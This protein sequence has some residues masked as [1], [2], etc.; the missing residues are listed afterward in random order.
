[1]YL[2]DRGFRAN[3]DPG[4]GALVHMHRYGLD[5]TKTDAFFVSHAHPDHWTDTTVLLNGVARGGLDKKGMLVAPRSVLR[6]TELDDGRMLG[7]V[8]PK[9][10]QDMAQQVYEVRPGSELQLKGLYQFEATKQDHSDPDTI[11]MK[12]R[13]THGQLS[14]IPDTQYFEGIATPHK[15]SRVV[16]CQMTR[17]GD[18]RVPW[19]MCAEDVIKIAQEVNPRLMVLTHFGFKTLK[20]GDP[21][22]WAQYITQET[23]VPTVAA[24][25]G[26]RVSLDGNVELEFPQ[27]DILATA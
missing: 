8:I 10:Y 23:G 22:R 9:Y 24:V 27:R 13:L 3:I 14:Y 16:V 26:M 1:M 12:F 19:H 7:P 17:G 11:G 18:Q 20:E 21:S 25:D 15:G 2:Q 6:G 4:P 5:P